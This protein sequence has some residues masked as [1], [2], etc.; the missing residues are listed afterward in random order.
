MQIVLGL[1][2]LVSLSGHAQN[3]VTVRIPP[4]P[5]VRV[6]SYPSSA[7]Y[8]KLAP[9]PLAER[10]QRGIVPVRGLV[11]T[12]VNGGTLI[13]GDGKMMVELAGD[14]LND[15]VIFHHERIMQP[16]KRP[17]EAPKIA[18]V[19]PQ[20]KQLLIAGHY[21]EG[22][23]LALHAATAAGLP[24]GTMNHSEISPFT[25]HIAI[26]AA[27]RPRDYLRTVDFESGE[28]GV[29]WTDQRGDWVRKTFVSRPDNVAV[30]YLTPAA[31]QTLDA[32]ISV[33][34][35]QA[36]RGPPGANPR[37]GPP[38]QTSEVRYE[39]DFNEHRLIVMGHF[40]PEF[41]N[42]G[43]A[44][45]TRVIATGGTV[46]MEDGKIVIRGAQ[47][48]VLLTRIEW[49]ADYSR[50]QVDALARAVDQ[51]PADYSTL[52]DRQ[53]KVQSAI[54]DR[55]SMDFGGRSQFGMS[56]EELLSDQRKRIGYSPAL[57]EKM[58]DMGRYWLLAEGTGD[59]PSIAG[60][61]NI[62]VNLQIAP[63]AMADLPE[64][65]ETFTHWIEGLL[66]DSRVN[67]KNIFGAR[68]A[69]FTTHPDQEQGVMYHYAFNWPHLYW[70]SSG[71]WAYSP[72]WD[73]Y[74]TTGDRVFLREHI[75]PGLK[76]LALFYEDFLTETD[77]NGNYIFVPSYSPENWPA[78]SDSTPT[79]IN[80][81]MDISV[82]REVLTH[83]IQA[84]E[85]LGTDADQIPKWKAMLAKMPP[86]LLDT[87]GALKEW[88]WP[89]LEENQDHRHAS[90]LYGVWPGDE[91]DPDNTP[92]LAKAAWLADRKRAQGNA[93]GHGISHRALA[94]ARLKDSY[95]VNM[96][97]KQFFEQGYVGPTLRTSHNP[98]TTPMPD[99]Q[100]SIPT[101]MMEMLLYSRPG[102]IEVLPA[103]PATLISGSMK[104]M[105][106]RT[107]AKVDDLT[108]NMDTRSVDLTI[109]SRQKQDLSLIVRY[110]IESITA[111]AG[112][113]SEHPKPDATTCMLHLPEGTPVTIHL[114]L[115]MKKPS[116]WILNVPA[117][118]VASQP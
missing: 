71:G 91:I 43:F 116:D 58:F 33:N 25:I 31:G 16:W 30:Q 38:Q 83:L 77:A 53:R 13:S 89:T 54:I 65:S 69:F 15:D 47:S 76:E 96:E 68:G 94:A 42:I 27:G 61:L 92:L 44:G 9:M 70:I 50:E 5:P 55:M 32:T 49:Y 8:A 105:L 109:T 62:N 82:C 84:S 23:E 63:A 73:Y 46:T 114:K 98:Y 52:V 41:G 117:Q 107:F 113:L 56:S 28:L 64:A 36:R 90:H 80:A 110:G 10:I 115:G 66:P 11:S 1:I 86:Y 102:V 57:L 39:R 79:V 87:D 108:W 60:H 51:L 19:L 3:P 29:H 2:A 88:A 48:A 101:I 106:A 35:G 22:L 95:L 99:Q 59:F 93:S 14:P 34:T 20:V 112:V 7:A 72:I 100:G 17:F 4:K 75:V 118:E 26:P 81:T 24:P 45:V 37:G 85:V 12:G 21:R 40:R 6:A 111:P 104:G 78:N 103:L 74:L 97:L 67:A 18:N